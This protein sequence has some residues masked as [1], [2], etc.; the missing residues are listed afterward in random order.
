MARQIS[1]IILMCLL[2][3]VSC[4]KNDDEISKNPNVSNQEETEEGTNTEEQSPADETPESG[5]GEREEESGG[6]GVVHLPKD[7]F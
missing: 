1:L 4:T 2:L 5:S 7:E 6:D 3:L